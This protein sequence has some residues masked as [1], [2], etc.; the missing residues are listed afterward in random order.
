MYVCIQNVCDR[1]QYNLVTVANKAKTYLLE[2]RRHHSHRSMFG[3]APLFISF[4]YYYSSP[5]N[6]I[7]IQ[8]G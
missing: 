7:L 8:L 3:R 5:K 2:M 6:C 1:A 4:E